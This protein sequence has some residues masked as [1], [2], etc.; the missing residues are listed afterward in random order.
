M[1]PAENEAKAIAELEPA[2]EVAPDPCLPIARVAWEVARTVA[3]SFG[4]F[5]KGPWESRSKAE[6]DEAVALTVAYLNTPAMKPST[7]A[8]KLETQ[9]DRAVAFA[10]FGTVRGI[11]QEQTR[12]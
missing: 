12:T 11:A 9:Q 4:D 8:V 1:I 2:N 6:Q 7:L 10:F 5:S 3:T